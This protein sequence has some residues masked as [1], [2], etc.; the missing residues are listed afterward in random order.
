MN[1]FGFEI[2]GSEAELSSCE[3]GREGDLEFRFLG[4][5][6]GFVSI[7][8]IVSPVKNGRCIFDTRLINKGEHVP[9]LI[10][11]NGAVT[12]PKIVKGQ[13]SVQLAD[14]SQDYVRK[15]SLRE[16][17]LESK[18]AELES[19]IEQISNAVYRNTIL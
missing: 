12:L 9:T 5:G 19:R 8:G 14:Y 4:A 11:N 3:S 18:V 16:R 17:R 15:I 7:D 13:C 1:R 2:F 6:E 10:T